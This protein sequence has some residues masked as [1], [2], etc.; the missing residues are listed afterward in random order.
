VGPG[1]LATVLV[2]A[3]RAVAGRATVADRDWDGR[4]VDVTSFSDHLCGTG[5]LSRV[6]A[7][8]DLSDLK[9]P[10]PVNRRP[11]V[12]A[13]N[14]IRHPSSMSTV[15]KVLPPVYLSLD[16]EMAPL[17]K[18]GEV[19]PLQVKLVPV[20]MV[21]GQGEPGLGVVGVVAPFAPPVRPLLDQRGDLGPV[22]GIFP[23]LRALDLLDEG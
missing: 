14:V 12:V 5:P 4:D 22:L 16:P 17:A 8:V 13:Y 7:L 2:F 18:R 15:E 1:A 10:F 9:L 19:P 21:D 6:V 23:G 20:E 3:G 11:E